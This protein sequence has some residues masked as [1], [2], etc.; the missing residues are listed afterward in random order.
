MKLQKNIYNSDFNYGEFA[1]IKS[2]ICLNTFN[3]TPGKW[4]DATVAIGLFSKSG[5]CI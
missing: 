3:L 4:I 2:Q 5:R 1:I